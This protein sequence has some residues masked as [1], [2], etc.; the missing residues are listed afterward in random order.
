MLVLILAAQLAAAGRDAPPQA[1]TLAAGIEAYDNLEFRRAR[2]I[3]KSLL[4]KDLEPT[5]RT[6]VLAYLARSLAVLEQPKMAHQRFAQVLELDPDFELSWEESPRIR[7]AFAA[8][9]ETVPAVRPEPEAASGAELAQPDPDPQL[10]PVQPMVTGDS[11]AKRVRSKRK[12]KAR[13]PRDLFSIETKRVPDEPP[14]LASPDDDEGLSTTTTL[15][16]VGGA[17]AAVGTIVAIVL[18]ATAGDD[19]GNPRRWQLP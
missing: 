17:V 3:L 18:F 6:Q 13:G 1:A 10:V 8:A 14:V 7:E 11:P 16:I 9:R 12:R 19:P 4:E 2:L 15:L 5:E